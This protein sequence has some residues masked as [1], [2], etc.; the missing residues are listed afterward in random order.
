MIP[1][2]FRGNLFGSDAFEAGRSFSGAWGVELRV[3]LVAT[4]NL[5]NDLDYSVL[6]QNSVL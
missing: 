6:N 1:P 2:L 4:P 5:N 3:R